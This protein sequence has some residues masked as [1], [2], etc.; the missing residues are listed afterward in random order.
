MLASDVGDII[1]GIDRCDIPLSFKHAL[2]ASLCAATPR[3][4][5]I[6]ALHQMNLA[7]VALYALAP[8]YKQHLAA[9]SG[10][11]TDELVQPVS[12]TMLCYLDHAIHILGTHRR[13]TA[14]L[15]CAVLAHRGQRAVT[16]AIE[17]QLLSAVKCGWGD[18]ERLALSIRG[19]SAPA[20]GLEP[21]IMERPFVVG[22]LDGAKWDSV[23]YPWRRAAHLH[24]LDKA[25][26]AR[27][28]GV[29]L[30]A[31]LSMIL[32]LDYPISG[33][34]LLRFVKSPL[35]TISER[36]PAAQAL[37]DSAP[38]SAVM[39]V[40]N[41]MAEDSTLS[42]C[43]A[44]RG[45]S[46]CNSLWDVLSP[47]NARDMVLFARGAMAT[48]SDQRP[49]G[50]RDF[51]QR[52]RASWA[53]VARVFS[54]CL[55][56]NARTSRLMT[57]GAVSR[58]ARALC[59][60]SEWA[61]PMCDYFSVEEAAAVLLHTS[62]SRKQIYTR[63]IDIVANEEKCAL[64]FNDH[65]LKRLARIGATAAARLCNSLS[66]ADWHEAGHACD[67]ILLFSSSMIHDPLEREA[68]FIIASAVPPWIKRV[69]ASADRHTAAERLAA[70]RNSLPKWDEWHLDDLLDRLTPGTLAKRA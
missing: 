62:I 10:F 21:T 69:T 33:P 49:V 30:D 32:A 6:R 2:C 13:S 52:M 11:F 15:V 70:M 59:L 66:T 36:D 17:E 67:G 34:F 29:P 45:M 20:Q 64:L 54:A 16:R 9:T 56:H 68:L 23:L 40:A 50:E 42:P 35:W 18:V 7:R 14:L 61:I 8:T 12:D 41:N 53:H 60:R 27:S 5:T 55:L 28:A 47:T 65:F 46:A 3:S 44:A 26:S 22:S 24:M 43:D 57:S 63:M 58:A 37:L 19:D 1:Q 38:L 48:I 25:I 4:T 51:M 31:A 39:Y